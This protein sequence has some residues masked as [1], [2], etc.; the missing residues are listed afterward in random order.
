MYKLLYYIKVVT[1]TGFGRD[2]I[3]TAI[4]YIVSKKIN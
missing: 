1:N 3:G 4:T 2:T